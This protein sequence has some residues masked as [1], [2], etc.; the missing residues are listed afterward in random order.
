M[1]GVWMCNSR[2]RESVWERRRGWKRGR[3]EEE[4]ATNLLRGK[5]EHSS[6][7]QEIVDDMDHT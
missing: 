5:F 4:D 1:S 3:D 6:W 2:R 7:E